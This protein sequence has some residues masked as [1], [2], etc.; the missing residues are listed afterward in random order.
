MGAHQARRAGQRQRSVA[1]GRDDFAVGLGPQRPVGL[2]GDRRLDEVD[3]AVG[4]QEVGAAGVVAVG[5]LICPV[6][7]VI[8]SWSP[9]RSR[10][11]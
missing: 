5:V 1:I 6:G 2:D 9:V 4:E 8:D 10:Q 7:G 3:A 11:T